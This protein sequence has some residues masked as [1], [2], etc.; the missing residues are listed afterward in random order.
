MN[1]YVSMVSSMEYAGAFLSSCMI[2]YNS[3]SLVYL[4]SFAV[5]DFHLY[6]HIMAVPLTGLV[7]VQ[8]CCIATMQ[9]A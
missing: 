6:M 3:M 7:L 1:R 9:R 2:T 5:P 8:Y 4:V